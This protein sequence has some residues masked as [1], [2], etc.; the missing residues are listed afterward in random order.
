MPHKAIISIRKLIEK[1]TNASAAILFVYTNAL[2]GKHKSLSFSLVVNNNK[3][4]KTMIA[5]KFKWRVS[6]VCTLPNTF[7][8]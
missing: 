8:Q 4:N 3:K 6:F 2:L 1:T 5:T 7:W